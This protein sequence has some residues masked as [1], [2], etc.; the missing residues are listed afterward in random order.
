MAS[1]VKAALLDGLGAA[2]DWLAG[3]IRD[4]RLCRWRGR[5]NGDSDFA[6]FAPAW[7]HRDSSAMEKPRRAARAECGSV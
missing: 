6:A 4:A 5:T 1:G 3:V 7:R 2:A